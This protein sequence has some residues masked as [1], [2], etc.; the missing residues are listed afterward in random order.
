MSITSYN[1]AAGISDGAGLARQIAL[2]PSVE[3]I[4]ALN[5][6]TQIEEI[7]LDPLGNKLPQYLQRVALSRR[8]TYASAQKVFTEA[9]VLPLSDVYADRIASILLVEVGDCKTVNIWAFADQA[10][11]DFTGLSL[12]VLPLLIT[13]D[14][15]EPIDEPLYINGHLGV[16]VLN[17]FIRVEQFGVASR[18][19]TLDVSNCHYIG[20]VVPAMTAVAGTTVYLNAYTC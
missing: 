16:Q 6:T 17:D 19:I 18:V 4:Y 15:G 2:T 12:D 11:N 10:S 14:G 9:D 1:R 13:D 5:E 8:Q 7:V 20:L 3:A